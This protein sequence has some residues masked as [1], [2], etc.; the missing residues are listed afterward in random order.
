M[1]AVIFTPVAPHM[2]F[3]RTVI[4]N[5]DEPVALRVLPHSGVPRSVSTGSRAPSSSPATG[6]A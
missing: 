6:S 5:A 1:R 2:A 3:N 4:A